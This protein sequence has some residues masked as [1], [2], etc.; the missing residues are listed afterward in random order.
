MRRENLKIRL[1]NSSQYIPIWSQLQYLL[2]TAIWSVLSSKA[3]QAWSALTDHTNCFVLDK[4]VFLSQQYIAGVTVKT[5][6]FKNCSGNILSLQ[7]LLHF[8]N[9]WRLLIN[10]NVNVMSMIICSLLNCNT[11]VNCFHNSRED[12]QLDSRDIK[13]LLDGRFDN[14]SHP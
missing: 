2:A 6:F 13:S 10:L 14:P 9:K 3:F 7:V 8:F 12:R 1:F 5:V 11:P 4:I